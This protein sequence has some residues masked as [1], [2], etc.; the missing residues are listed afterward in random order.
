MTLVNMRR[1]MSMLLVGGLFAAAMVYS[2]AAVS[3][4]AEGLSLCLNVIA[5]TLLPFFVLSNLLC[6]LG[7]PGLVGRFAEPGFRRLFGVSGAGCGAFILG[8]T[9]G[10]PLGAASVCSIYT[11]GDISRSD[12]ERLL[13]FC[14]NTG[15]AFIIGMA[16]IGVFRSSSIGL[17][18]YICHALAAVLAGM[19]LCSGKRRKLP[20]AG[21]IRAR[22]LSPALT[23][24]MLRA[25]RST[26]MISGFVVFF[27]AL[28]AL[29]RES[30]LFTLL[31][32]L[33][34]ENTPMSLGQ[35][36]CLL[37]GLLELGSG[38]AG[39]SGLPPTPGNL[40]LCSFILGWGSLSVQMQTAAV[41]SPSGLKG[42]GCVP[43]K[44]LHGL[45][46]ASLAWMMGI[47]L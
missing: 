43:A 25:L 33:L 39:M 28:A 23:D 36:E 19:L 32:G 5:P 2:P 45:I 20:D 31:T 18:L 37:T 38:I 30:G 16:G 46:A 9:G 34:W 17:G 29:M 14:N 8:L 26:A 24:A 40:A 44:L 47:I 35:S 10:Y 3:G 42:T 22:E 41:I 15:P 6:A 21:I 27:S 13:L 7:L 4:A 11:Q 12:A 1:Y